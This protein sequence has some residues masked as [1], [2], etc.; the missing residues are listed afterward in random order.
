MQQTEDAVS[1]PRVYSE[2]DNGA[3]NGMEHRSDG[4]RLRELGWFGPEKRRLRGGLIG[5]LKGGCGEVGVSLYSLVTVIGRKGMASGCDRMRGNSQGRFR[6]DNK[7]N[8]NS[9]RVVRQWH[10][11]PRQVM[12]SLSLEMFKKYGDVALRDVV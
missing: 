6:L 3:V 8:N 7:K 11:L 2:K 12:E 5:C 10:R 1:V 9:K 4:E